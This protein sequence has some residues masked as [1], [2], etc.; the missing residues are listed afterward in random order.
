MEVDLELEYLRKE[1]FVYLQVSHL[2]CLLGI[3]TYTLCI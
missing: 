3:T 2:V 1:L